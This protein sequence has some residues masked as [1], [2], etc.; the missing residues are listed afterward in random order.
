MIT[1]WIDRCSVPFCLLSFREIKEEMLLTRRWNF[2][3]S[4]LLFLD[5]S[6]LSSDAKL[7]GFDGPGD[8]KN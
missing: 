4:R 5:I 6:F 3:L 2:F 8:Q 7:L 1:G